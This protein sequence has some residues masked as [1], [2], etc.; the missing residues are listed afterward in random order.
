MQKQSTLKLR[1]LAKGWQSQQVAD[2][3]GV[4]PSHYSYIENGR[5]LPSDQVRRKL[6]EVFG[7]T[8]ETVAGWLR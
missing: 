5:R 6:A 2:A 3:L 4:S 8:V 1:R 7:V